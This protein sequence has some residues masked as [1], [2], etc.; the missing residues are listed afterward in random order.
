MEYFAATLPLVPKIALRKGG[1]GIGGEH[2]YFVL[3][4]N[5]IRILVAAMAAIVGLILLVPVLL[6]AIPLWSVSILTRGV[7]R[8][9]EPRFLTRDQLSRI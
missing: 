7:S 1:E 2:L 6:L 3:M 5:L 8:L 9:L 4:M